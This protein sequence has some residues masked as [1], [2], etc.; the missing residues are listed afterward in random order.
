MVGGGIVNDTMFKVLDKLRLPD[1]YCISIEG[2]TQLLKS[3]LPL[4]DEKG[5]HFEIKT[6]GMTEYQNIEDYKKYADVVLQGDAEN[7]GTT[8][9]LDEKEHKKGN[10]N[11]AR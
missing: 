7:I 2:D 11:V 6:V 1:M 5:N 3:G 4:I 9:F 10:K 8:L